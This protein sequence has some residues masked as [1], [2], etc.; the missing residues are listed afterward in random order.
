MAI[1]FDAEVTPDALT[2][3]VREVPTP[4]NL[5]FY[6]NIG[7]KS[8]DDHKVDF[9]ELVHTNRTAKF[10]AFDG[11]LPTMARDGGSTSEVSL[12][13]LGNS[14]NLGEYER[15][16][17]QFA[18]TSG[19]NKAALANAIYNDAENLTSSVYNR[20]ELAWGDVLTDGKLTID[21]NG[22]KGE[23]D[24]GVPT[25]NIV[26]AAKSWTDP[27][28]PI[29]DDL[30]SWQQAYVDSGVGAPGAIRAKLK[31]IRLMQRNEQLVRA[32]RGPANVSTSQRVTAQELRDFLAS[33]DL[34]PLVELPDTSLDVDGVA[35]KVMQD[36]KV[37]FTPANLGDLG[38][39][40]LGV[41][42][43]ALELVNS[44][45][46]EMTFQGAAGLVGIV[47]KVGPP[48][49]QF[50]YVDATAMPILSQPKRLFIASV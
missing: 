12:L 40:A 35:T 6:S 42:V 9:S 13:P 43:T 49:R 41:S 48:Y 7:T 25:G 10:R 18:R 2:A 46:A 33:E 32:I 14:M 11:G 24:F 31:T 19:T 1:F 4:A 39:T 8:V 15:L 34:P 26:S 21:E 27:T 23:A 36:G 29:L 37:L 50:T 16:Q 38:F 44:K 17:I 20:L 5:A 45:H 22:Y 30:L 28:A 3:F 47:E